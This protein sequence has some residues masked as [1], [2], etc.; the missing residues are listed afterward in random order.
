MP[1]HL[2]V[3]KPKT[4]ITRSTS[5]WQAADQ[6]HFIHPFTDQAALHKDGARIIE[7]GQGVCI[8]DSEGHRLIDG[9]AGL[10]CVNVGY[11]Q[12]SLIEAAHEQ[13]KRLAYYNAFFHTAVPSSIELAELLA[14][15]S[16]AQFRRVY[17]TNS[18][19]EGN[20]TV[21]RLVRHYWNLMGQPQ[22]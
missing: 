4:M 15:V 12:V 14:E 16:P 1:I 20:D 13:L 7:S 8:T 17:Y 6:A 2:N 3:S 21:I 9:M 18:G 11:G 22:R 19:S 10:W 5:A